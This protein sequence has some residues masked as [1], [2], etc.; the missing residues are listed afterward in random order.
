MNEWLCI[1]NM[2]LAFE[3]SDDMITKVIKIMENE[4]SIDELNFE[5]TCELFDNVL[6]EYNL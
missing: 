5:D 3:V 4:Y 2:K 6:C 1:E